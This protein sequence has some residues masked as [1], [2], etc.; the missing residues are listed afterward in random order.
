MGDKKIG[1][2]VGN[3]C[4]IC[5]NGIVEYIGGCNTCTSCLAQLKCGL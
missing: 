2:E 4:P 3:I 1:I 5:R